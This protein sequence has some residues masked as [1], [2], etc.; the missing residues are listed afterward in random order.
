M[1]GG[2]LEKQVSHED[3]S[4]YQEEAITVEKDPGCSCCCVEPYP[5]VF[6][7]HS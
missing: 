5:V 6:R 2:Q 4:K 3:F 1:D 7:R